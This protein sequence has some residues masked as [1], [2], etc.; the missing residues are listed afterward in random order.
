MVGWLVLLVALLGHEFV[1][2]AT[3]PAK[4]CS[5]SDV[6]K[7]VGKATHGDTVSIPA[8]TQTNWTSQLDIDVGITLTGAGEGKTT[9]GDDVV[10]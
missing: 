1:Q 6:A 4:S 8:C 7:A 3:I 10:K 9:I 5:R 2:A